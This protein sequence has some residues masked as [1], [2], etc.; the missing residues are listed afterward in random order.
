MAG[1]AREASLIYQARRLS[2]REEGARNIVP[3][4]LASRPALAGQI[5]LNRAFARGRGNRYPKSIHINFCK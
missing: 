2:H 5:F 1:P 4:R 3:A